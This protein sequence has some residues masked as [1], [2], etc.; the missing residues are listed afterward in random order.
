MPELAPIDPDVPQTR[1]QQIAL[2][3]LQ[4]EIQEQLQANLNLLPVSRPRRGGVRP[5]PPSSPPKQPRAAGVVNP[6]QPG[7]LNLA[8]NNATRTNSLGSKVPPP[9]TGFKDLEEALQ[10]LRAASGK[11]KEGMQP[12]QAAPKPIVMPKLLV[13]PG[14]VPP[15]PK[16]GCS[17]VHAYK[18][19]WLHLQHS[20]DGDT[21]R[22]QNSMTS[23]PRVLKDRFAPAIV[24]P[25]LAIH[26]FI[27]SIGQPSIMFPLELIPVQRFSFGSPCSAD[28]ISVSADQSKIT[29]EALVRGVWESNYRKSD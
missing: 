22:S 23:V 7:A 3:A 20:N 13:D 21:M 17:S 2:Q 14:L 18:P 19:R 6:A 12:T 10:Q 4:P 26:V 28:S 29:L 9:P 5:K 27:L 16:T 8:V 11:L 25:I 24:V 1:A 15:P